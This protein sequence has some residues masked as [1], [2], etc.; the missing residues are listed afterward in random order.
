[1]DLEKYKRLKKKVED[2]QQESTR[3]EGQLNGLMKRLEEEHG[4]TTLKQ[5]SAKAVNMQNKLTKLEN[6]FDTA[7]EKFEEKWGGKVDEID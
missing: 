4:C 3:A 5:A 7:L 2:L 6:D 1:M